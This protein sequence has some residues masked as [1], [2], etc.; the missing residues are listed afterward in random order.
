MEDI[1]VFDDDFCSLVAGDLQAKIADN[2]TAVVADSKDLAGALAKRLGCAAGEAVQA[3]ATN[4]GVDFAAGTGKGR[5]RQR[6]RNRGKRI[7]DGKEAERNQAV[8]RG[9]GSSKTHS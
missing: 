7:Q 1:G 2:K 5:Q 3:N 4:L 6:G 9:E 8:E